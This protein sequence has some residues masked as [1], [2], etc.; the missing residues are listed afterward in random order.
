M[1]RR[2]IW[3]DSNLQRGRGTAE[4]DM[5]MGEE[6][7]GREH[8]RTIYNATHAW[9]AITKPI[10]LLLGWLLKVCIFSY[11]PVCAG[12]WADERSV[13][14]GQKRTMEPMVWVL[15]TKLGASAEATALHHW[16]ISPASKPITLH[17]VLKINLK[18]VYR[19]VCRTKAMFSNTLSEKT[20]KSS[21]FTWNSYRKVYWL[22]N[23]RSEYVISGY[24]AHS[25]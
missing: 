14:R 23:L 11:V 10:T 3:H 8:T 2:N 17:A 20:M 25:W 18:A 22:W 19:L 12:V 4:Q 15:G 7:K 9:N 21:F 5:R 6:V 13:C 16:V 1:K 24:M